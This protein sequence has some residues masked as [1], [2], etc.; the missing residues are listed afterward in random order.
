MGV[1][2]AGVL[3]TGVAIAGGG[4]RPP[5][6]QWVP[7]R[8]LACVLVAAWGAAAAFVAVHRPRETLSWI[9]VGGACGCRG[10][11]QYVV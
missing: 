10:H 4:S 5:T 9:M 3:A 6:S 8:V 2:A 7:G 11:E 1:A